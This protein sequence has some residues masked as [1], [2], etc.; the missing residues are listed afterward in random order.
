[1]NSSLTAQDLLKKYIA[2]PQDHGSWVFL[3]SPLLIGIIAGGA[4]I[5]ATTYLVITC[6]AA[7]LI[8]QPLTILVKALSGR[9]TRRELPAVYFWIGVYGLLAGLGIAGLALTGYSFIFYLAIP[10][11]PVFILHLYLISRRAERRQMGVEL[12]ATGVLA[13]AAPAAYW[14]GVGTP[15]VEGWHLWLLIWIQSA[16]SIV[17]AYLRLDQRVLENKPSLLE[18]FIMA[19]RALLYTTFNLALVGGLAIFGRLPALLPLPYLIQW[20]ESLWGALVRPAIGYKP[21]TIGI[22]QLIV[23]IIFTILF[24]IAWVWQP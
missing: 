19:R 2:L 5:S 18:R 6:M 24:I 20:A 1:M 15:A 23:S 16:A 12:V 11:A 14:V 3:L 22:R 7:F 17:Y 10:G 9:R 4:W 13:L 8:R 21:T